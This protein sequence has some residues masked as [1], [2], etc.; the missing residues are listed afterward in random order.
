MKEFSR[1][2]RLMGSQ[3][4]LKILCENESS[5]TILLNEAV[6]EIKRIE[7][8]LTE[9]DNESC[10]SR[11]NNNAGLNAV[12]VEK[13]VYDLLTRS[14]RISELTQ[15][16]FDITSG[17]LK[18]LYEFNNI[19]FQFPQKKNISEALNR[20][21]FQYI[22]LEKELKVFLEKK[23]MHISFAAIGKG[24]AA[25]RAAKM[26]QHKNV[27]AG[28]INASGDLTVWGKK[29]DDSAWKVGIAD[30]A[31][32]SKILCWVALENTSVAT[33]GDYYQHFIYDG[34]K[35]SHNIDPKTGLPLNGLKS[36]TIISRSAELSDALA[37]AVYVMGKSTGMHFVN[38][39]PDVH[40]IIID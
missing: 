23:D 13:E 19:E 26:L 27:V 39:L 1:H 18:K 6:E 7:K 37:T 16:A 20:V 36:V 31:D 34:V 2:E 25:D 12:E 14:I 35:Y 4:E 28:V 10:T 29:K 5:A 22:H 24:Y 8:L 32:P 38:Q 9:F 3:F 17:V 15:G 40:C 21:G 33:S 11:I 30:P